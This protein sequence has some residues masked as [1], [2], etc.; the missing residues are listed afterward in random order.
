MTEDSYP[1]NMIGYGGRPP[2]PTGRAAPIAVQFVAELRGGRREQPPPRRRRLGGVPLRDPERP[3]LAG[4][5]AHGTWNRSTST[6]PRRLLAA[7]GRMFTERG[8]AA[9]GLRRGHGPATQPARR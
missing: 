8:H 3:A 6:A 4:D 1:R 5:A 7:P 2:F 9:H